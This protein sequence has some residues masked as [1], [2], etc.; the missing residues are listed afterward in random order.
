MRRT[1]TWTCVALALAACSARADVGEFA[2]LAHRGSWI[3]RW[4]NEAGELADREVTALIWNDAIRA[5][6]ERDGAVHLPRRDTP[7]YLDGPVVLK[8]GQK[9]TADR[10]AEIRLK[11]GT[12]TCMV[13]NENVVG[14]M[15]GPVPEDP[16]P[17]R[18]ITIE[19][20]IW[21]TLAV[22]PREANGNQRGHSS[23]E[24]PVPGTHGVI[25]LHNAR[26]ITVRNI[27]VRESKPFAVHL[28]NVRDFVVEGLALERHRRD[29]VHVNGPASRGLI[30]DISGDSHDDPVALN[31]WDWRN[32]LTSYGPI[33]D[34]TVE[35]VTGAPEEKKATD[36]IRLL[37]GVKRFP[38]GTVVDCYLKN[39]VLRDITDIRDFKFYNQPNLEL[40]RD[41]DFSDGLGTMEN[42]RLENLVFNRPG[43]IQVHADLDGL[44]IDGVSV[45]F[46]P[47]PAW[48]LLEIGPKS[49]TY[50]HRPEDPSSW[51][52]IFSPDLDCTVKNVKISGV[53]I[54]GMEGDVPVERLVR[55][56][57]LQPNPGYPGTVPKGGTG[58]GVWIR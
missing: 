39:I 27:V 11:P 35:R 37:P 45:R 25:L 33:H 31:A 47:T 20:G 38:D 5:A 10:D 15:E 16:E 26:N 55:E 34:I 1:I 29:G 18:G 12:N 30:R 24:N 58:R 3:E 40:G 36:A 48:R 22:S 46:T 19:G 49:Q 2:T 32:Y 17:D 57:Q 7:Y 53:R 21:T 50:K 13:R 28:C 23:K 42:I 9:L 4:P 52:E 8:S 6:L 51:V 56:V 14:F 44:A 43:S 54:P 41:K